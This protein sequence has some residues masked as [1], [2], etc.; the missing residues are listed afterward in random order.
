MNK[1]NKILKQEKGIKL[2]SDSEISELHDQK[3]VLVSFISENDIFEDNKTFG[4][5]I[6]GIFPNI[7]ACNK[8]VSNIHSQENSIEKY[9]S[10][11]PLTLGE[12]YPYMG[13]NIKAKSKYVN[14]DLDNIIK[15]GEDEDEKVTNFLKTRKDLIKN[16]TYLGRPEKEEDIIY[17]MSTICDSI[18]S[19]KESIEFQ[20]KS[21]KD[22]LFKIQLL[23]E[24]NVQNKDDVK[25]VKQ[26]INPKTIKNATFFNDDDFNKYKNVLCSFYL[27]NKTPQKKPNNF[28]IKFKAGFNT[29][30]EVN[31]YSRKL[32]DKYHSFSFP[33]G[34]WMYFNSDVNKNDSEIEKEFI[35]LICKHL[36]KCYYKNNEFENRKSESLKTKEMANDVFDNPDILIN[37]NSY[38]LD[39]IKDDQK[40]LLFYENALYENIK[41]FDELYKK[42]LPNDLKQKIDNL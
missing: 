3:I 20:K 16:S 36:N 29:P 27:G 5:K 25:N 33:I 35:E 6:R 9:F 18:K 41:V 1:L 22:N 10:M 7:E 13:K 28:G 40:D 2:N 39:M 31:L 8:F 32:K 19:S 23:K 12:W 4:L 21:V 38:I 42:D 24:K 14:E 34:E 11:S 37:M 15:A 26:N 17:L 30:E